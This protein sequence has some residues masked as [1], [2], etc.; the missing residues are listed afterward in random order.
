MKDLDTEL[1]GYKRRFY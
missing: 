1:T